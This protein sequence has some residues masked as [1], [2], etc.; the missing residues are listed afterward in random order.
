MSLE[1]DLKRMHFHGMGEAKSLKEDLKK[2]IEEMKDRV[3]L[4][5]V[6]ELVAIVQEAITSKDFE[7][8]NIK[9]LS[10]RLT[11][12]HESDMSY[13]SLHC[14]DSNYDIVDNSP[15]HRRRDNPFL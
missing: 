1:E 7:N 6:I 15:Y 11:S 12:N 5:Q 3:H 2:Q 9:H 4:Y 8:L 10:L 13:L 14:M